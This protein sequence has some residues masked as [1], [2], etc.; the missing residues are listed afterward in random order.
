M[1]SI[2]NR[3]KEKSE[4][5]GDTNC[6]FCQL[7]GWAACLPAVTPDWLRVVESSNQIRSWTSVIRETLTPMNT[8]S[9]STVKVVDLD[10][11]KT[12][13]ILLL[14]LSQR[15]YKQQKILTGF[16]RRNVFRELITSHHYY[17]YQSELTNAENYRS[18][19]NLGYRLSLDIGIV[20]VMLEIW[21]G[22]ESIDPSVNQGWAADVSVRSEMKMFEKRE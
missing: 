22:E 16:K 12:H 8:K 13:A 17:P 2:P 15:C 10:W 3:Q 5:V 11:D 14:N 20:E 18:A 1:K 21:K 7:G 6:D 19:M 9:L 4:R